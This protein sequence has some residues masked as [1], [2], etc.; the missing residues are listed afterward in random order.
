ML[1]RVERHM[2]GMTQLRCCS[3]WAPDSP[4]LTLPAAQYHRISPPFPQTN[5]KIQPTSRA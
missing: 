3:F 1:G 5:Q 2:L 4:R